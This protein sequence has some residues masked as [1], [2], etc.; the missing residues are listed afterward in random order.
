VQHSYTV[1]VSFLKKKSDWGSGRAKTLP[2]APLPSMISPRTIGPPSVA[3][4]LA[5]SEVNVVRE[6]APMDEVFLR[7]LGSSQWLRTGSAGLLVQSAGPFLFFPLVSSWPSRPRQMGGEI[8]PFS[9]I[10]VWRGG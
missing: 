1:P 3:T 2:I 4:F 8:E 7:V 6:G 9:S 5:A 10:F